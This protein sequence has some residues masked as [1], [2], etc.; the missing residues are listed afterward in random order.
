M[1]TRTEERCTLVY[2]TKCFHMHSSPHILL[3]VWFLF[4][5]HMSTNT[6]LAEISVLHC[7]QAFMLLNTYHI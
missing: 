6:L 5:A 2:S 3:R 4:T 7:T 1:T